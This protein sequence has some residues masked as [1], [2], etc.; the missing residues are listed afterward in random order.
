MAQNGDGSEPRGDSCWADT[1]NEALWLI[2]STS[3][4]TSSRPMP[5]EIFCP[6]S[7]LSAFAT[8][9]SMAWIECSLKRLSVMQVFLKYVRAVREVLDLPP[10]STDAEAAYF[11]A[12]ALTDEDSG[13]RAL[14]FWMRR[15]D[16]FPRP[17]ELREVISHLLSAASVKTGAAHGESAQST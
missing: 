16:R 15:V 10:F 17:H 6:S 12:V 14:R 11:D 3:L 2:P 4:E 8:H 5:T 13:V 1:L 7:S 9:A